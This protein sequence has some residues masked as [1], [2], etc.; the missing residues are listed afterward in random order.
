MK[1]SPKVW[2]TA[3]LLAACTSSAISQTIFTYGSK[4][5]SKGEFLKA[6]NKNN[7]AEKPTDRSYREYL[8]LYTRFKIKVQA[9]YDLKLDTL[10]EQLA[11]LTGF[12]SQ[13]VDNYMNDDG[14]V[15][16][17]VAEAAARARKDIHVAHIFLPLSQT[18]LP[19]E[20]AS[21]EVKLRAILARV[22]KGDDFSQLALELSSD[23][24]VTV[25][26]GDIGYIT[27]FV[28]P[29]DMETAVYNTAPGKVSAPVRSPIGYHLFKNLGTRP[30]IGKVSVAQILIGFTQDGTEEQK[31][32]DRKLADSVYRALKKGAD[33]KEMVSKFSSDNSTYQAGGEIMEF[34]VGRYSPA[35]EQ[36]AFALKQDG[37]LSEPFETEYGIHIIK[38][39]RRNPVPADASDKTYLDALRQQ[40]LQ[41]DRMAFA[42]TIFYNRIKKDIQYKKAAY[43]VQSVLAIA[44]SL[45]QHKSNPALKPVSD[46]TTLFTF[47]T[48]A[49]RVSDWT[50]Y[51]HSM[52]RLENMRHLPAQQL[53]DNFLE[54][55]AF[56]YYRDNLEK[57]NPE[58]A[59]Q[60]HEF[61]EGNLLFE[62][63]Q[64]KIWG[65]A[66]E[67][68]AALKRYYD[69]NKSRYWWEASADAVIFTAAN[70]AAATALRSKLEADPAQWKTLAD[71]SAG[72][73]QADSGRFELGQIPV[74]E[75]TNFTDGL[76]TAPIKNENDNTV[77][78]AY[79][80]KVYRDRHPRSF[81]DARG[82]VV[83]DYQTQ[84]ENAWIKDLQKKYPVK[85]NNEVVKSLPK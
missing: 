71:N 25:N 12:R 57:Y 43:P 38:R 15:N 72:A 54:R 75:R 39:L 30:A 73:V 51:L 53:F 3:A 27:A 35:F 59:Y 33:W 61:K 11:E 41:S 83:N 68:S 82:F 49:Y 4:P 62:V 52:M 5:V 14:S 76:I 22:Q 8:D 10:P 56:D 55:S 9:A 63:M 6:Y 60:L 47:G 67:D 29:Y 2:A 34:G 23:P 79:I 78:F 19:A 85:V 28:L 81:N 1:P 16:Q 36:A 65:V 46:K 64:R 17:L 50:Q 48:K 18:A 74:F 77:S 32:A 20:A 58:F 66:N 45:L 7:A 31:A 42:K 13:V 26:K 24:A 44:D 21:T 69:A 40:V 80:I 70:E 37:E 84:L